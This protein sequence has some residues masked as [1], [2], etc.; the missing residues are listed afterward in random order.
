MTLLGWADWGPSYCA[1]SMRQLS[2]RSGWCLETYFAPPPLIP[3]PRNWLMKSPSFK[4]VVSWLDR[5]IP[6]ADAPLVRDPVTGRV[7][8][9]GPRGTSDWK[10][11]RDGRLIVGVRVKKSG[12]SN[13]LLLAVYSLEPRTS[14]PWYLAILAITAWLWRIAARR[15]Q[16]PERA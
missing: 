7:I 16:K 5:N 3:F 13:Q 2:Y 8:W 6:K 12:T 14:W 15:H 4:G 9:N 10:I 11:S 1:E